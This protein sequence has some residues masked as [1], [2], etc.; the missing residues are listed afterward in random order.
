[1]GTYED[2]MERRLAD[3]AVA[4]RVI[5]VTD[6]AQRRVL[7]VLAAARGHADLWA[8]AREDVRCH[9]TIGRWLEHYVFRIWSRMDVAREIVHATFPDEFN[10]FAEGDDSIDAF[11]AAIQAWGSDDLSVLDRD[12]LREV[13]E[14]A[15][16]H[17][18]AEAHRI[19]QRVQN[20]W[21]PPLRATTNDS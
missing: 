17:D 20:R 10:E 18:G 9:D 15:L 5:D 11:R 4:R 3:L 8:W 19:G 6:S 21:W 7:D 13:G 14:A 12:E 16:R 2:E 1:M